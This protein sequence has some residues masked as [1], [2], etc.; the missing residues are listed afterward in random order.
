[1][2]DIL[3]EAVRMHIFDRIVTEVHQ[4]CQIATEIV[5]LDQNIFDRKML[6]D[7]GHNFPPTY[8]PSKMMAAFCD[9]I[10]S[11]NSVKMPHFDRK[12]LTDFGHNFP[13]HTF[14]GVGGCF[15]DRIFGQ[16]LVKKK[17]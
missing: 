1:M 8:I 10:S 11:Q 15:F 13:P 2:A 4:N 7:F 12:I 6:A 17:F 9:R 5:T 3:R 14:L 16:N